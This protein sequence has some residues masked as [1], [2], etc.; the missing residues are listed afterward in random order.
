MFSL[1]SLLLVIL[2]LRRL[3]SFLARLW[4]SY[5]LLTS[6]IKAKILSFLLF[7]VAACVWKKDWTYEIENFNTKQPGTTGMSEDLWALRVIN[8]VKTDKLLFFLYEDGKNEYFSS[9]KIFMCF[10]FC[11][12]LLVDIFSAMASRIFEALG[13]G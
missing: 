1:G 7:S 5:S 3:F 10:Y 8:Y 6:V 2:V 11:C 9:K 12:C 4:I 13:N